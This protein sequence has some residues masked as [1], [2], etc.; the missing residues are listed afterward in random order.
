[1]PSPISWPVDIEYELIEPATGFLEN[2]S[3]KPP[4][5]AQQ[6]ESINP[7]EITTVTSVGLSDTKR[8]GG[9]DIDWVPSFENFMAR[10]GRLSKTQHVRTMAL[11]P[12]FPERI[13]APRAWAGQ[14]F[15]EEK[16]YIY[17][18][19]EAEVK[20]IEEALDYFKG[21]NFRTSWSLILGS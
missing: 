20:E 19:S 13:E 5:M 17:V 14:E 11:P 18:L 15:S 3:Q 2:A 21:L 16:S 10:V 7:R 8:D 4:V 1:M 6:E 12:G 9:P